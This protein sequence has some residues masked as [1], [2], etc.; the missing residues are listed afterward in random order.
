M[1]L[2]SLHQHTVGQH[3]T[4]SLLYYKVLNIS[5]NVLNNVLKVKLKKK[6]CM[7]T[8]PLTGWLSVCVCVYIFFFFFTFTVAWLTWRS[9]ITGEHHVT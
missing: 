2:G 1:C 9:S 3:L 6:G 5:Y 8:K 4:Q 7:F